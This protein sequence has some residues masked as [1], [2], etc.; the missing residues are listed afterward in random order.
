[1][2]IIQPHSTRGGISHFVH[3]SAARGDPG[4]LTSPSHFFFFFFLPDRDNQRADAQ[5]QEG[6]CDLCVCV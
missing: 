3:S 6:V 4:F 5:F 2:F 1:M